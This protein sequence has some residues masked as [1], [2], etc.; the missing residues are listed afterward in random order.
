MPAPPIMNCNDQNLE[1]HRRRIHART[2]D[3]S[4]WEGNRQAIGRS[5]GA[6]PINWAST[7]MTDP[8]C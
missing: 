2:A 5:I 6:A 7:R 3:L 8:A 4:A 1:Y